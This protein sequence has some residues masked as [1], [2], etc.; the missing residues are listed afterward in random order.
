MVAGKTVLAYIGEVTRV[1]VV[2]TNVVDR[3]EVIRHYIRGRFVPK[4]ARVGVGQCYVGNGSVSRGSPLPGKFIP[5]I[6]RPAAR[7]I[8]N[9]PF[10]VGSRVKSQVLTS[11]GGQYGVGHFR[12]KYVARADCP[13]K[14][15]NPAQKF[16]YN[17]HDLVICQGSRQIAREYLLQGWRYG[18]LMRFLEHHAPSVI[19]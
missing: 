11:V 12:Q 5:V 17:G 15:T 4:V 7:G 16:S 9:A 1:E 18:I 13:V 3:L 10:G 2:K 14:K 6:Y 8:Q 19:S